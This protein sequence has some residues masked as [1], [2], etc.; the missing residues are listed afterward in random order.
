MLCGGWQP[1]ICVRDCQRGNKFGFSNTGIS[2]VF[3]RFVD[4]PFEFRSDAPRI[5]PIPP[6]AMRRIRGS[7]LTNRRNEMGIST[8]DRQCLR[9]FS[10]GAL[11]IACLATPLWSQALPSGPT[12]E[13]AVSEDSVEPLTDASNELAD[14]SLDQLMDVDVTSVTGVR[15]S[16]FATPAAIY[17]LRGDDIAAAGHLTLAESLRLVPGIHVARTSSNMWGIGTRGFN[18]RLSNKQLVMIDG[19]VVYDP[20]FAGVLWDIQQP[21]LADISQVE[22]I[23]GPGATL[24]GSNAVNGVINVTSLSARDTQGGLVSAT[25]GIGD[26]SDKLDLRYGGKLATDAYYRVYGQWIESDNQEFADGS[27]A[28]DNW[29][30][31]KG[32]VRFDFGRPG[33]VTLMLSAEVYGTD[34]IGT[35]RLISPFI[36]P[37]TGTTH[38]PVENT[39]G[40]GH[41]TARLAREIDAQGWQLQF[42]VDRFDRDTSGLHTR[43]T[44]LDLDWRHHFRPD[45]RNE[46]VY[47]LGLRTFMYDSSHEAD[48]DYFFD[49]ADGTK[50]TATAFIQDTYSLV[51][52]ELFLMLGTKVEHN[53][54]TGFEF[55][56]SARV[57]WTPNDKN[58]VWA[59]VSRSVRVPA[60]SDTNILLPLPFPGA[61]PLAVTTGDADSE[62]AWTYELGYR[63]RVTPDLTLDLATYYSRYSSLLATVPAPG[64]IPLPENVGDGHTYGVEASVQW[65]ATSDLAM[66]LGYAFGREELNDRYEYSSA[67]TMPE[68]MVHLGADYRVTH[69]LRLD[70]H[71]YFVDDWDDGVST[72][73]AYVR[74]DLGL[75]WQIRENCEFAIWG[76][77]LLDGRHPESSR[78]APDG[79]G[80]TTEIGR[81]AYAQ[82][83]FK[84]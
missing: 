28:E 82:L 12:T 31:L 55:Q 61:P 26:V 18:G 2:P 4:T 36:P 65:Q 17:V 45:D 51:P 79:Y 58:T 34:R 81:S 84:F 15:Q 42:V 60:L 22:I 14:L 74:V 76:Q 69:N 40:G 62:V 11:Q 24:W 8:F 46:V 32:G 29:D 9:T 56:P 72:V 13:R 63:T 78:G 37:P 10:A 5:L 6:E 30:L 77:N 7:P 80:D 44:V 19:R 68:H 54:Y 20:F 50:T 39:A 48:A 21:M 53:D 27:S 67:P 70:A 23:R 47:G 83:A 49:P 64:T 1:E 66:T 52:N 73:D 59:A 16:Y 41:L 75:R 3:A 35:Q 43:G 57:W 38:N 33:D 25:A 71:G